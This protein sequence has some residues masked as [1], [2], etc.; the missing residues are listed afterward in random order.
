MK[1]LRNTQKSILI[2]YK[3]NLNNQRVPS[4]ILEDGTILIESMAIVEYLDEVHPE[5]RLLPQDPI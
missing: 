5:P 1:N 2:K 3:N 4:L